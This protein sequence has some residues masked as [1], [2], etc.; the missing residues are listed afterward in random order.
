MLLIEHNMGLVME[1]ADTITVLNAGETLAYG[2]P[3]EIQ[4]KTDR[5]ALTHHN[6]CPHIARAGQRAKRYDFSDNDDQQCALGMNSI[7]Q[8]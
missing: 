8:R 4:A 3:A 5:L 6:V 2:T 1:L 7:G